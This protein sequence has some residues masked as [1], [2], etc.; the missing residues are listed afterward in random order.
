M[1]GATIL[2]SPPSLCYLLHPSTTIRLLLHDNDVLDKTWT[3]PSPSPDYVHAY[4]HALS[5]PCSVVCHGSQNDHLF[6]ATLVLSRSLTLFMQWIYNNG[7]FP[8]AA[9]SSSIL[10]LLLS[11]ISLPRTCS[12]IR[13]ATLTCGFPQS[14]FFPPHPPSELIMDDL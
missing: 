1:H 5:M 6:S 8:P 9:S 12:H 7:H 4:L 2:T 10:S 3:V 13:L 14:L 11:T